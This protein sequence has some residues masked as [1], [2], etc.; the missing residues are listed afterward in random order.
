MRS[1]DKFTA[2]VVLAFLG[3]LLLAALWARIFF[4][5]YPMPEE[6]T[7][8]YNMVADGLKIYS[9]VLALVL[10]VTIALALRKEWARKIWILLSALFIVFFARFAVN[11]LSADLSRLVSLGKK[12]GVVEMSDAGLF[13]VGGAVFVL[14]LAWS[15]ALLY[16][17][18]ANQPS[19]SL[20]AEPGEGGLEAR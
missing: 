2:M 4:L 1:D 14:L 11:I 12:V 7:D 3:F 6:A 16:F 8:A 18:L 19:A 15:L 5:V 17:C 9:V 13:S 10:V 20:T